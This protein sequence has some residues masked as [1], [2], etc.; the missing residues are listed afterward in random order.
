MSVACSESPFLLTCLLDAQ[1]E[2]KLTDEPPPRQLAPSD[3]E[4]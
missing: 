3:E 1:G 2:K 4:T